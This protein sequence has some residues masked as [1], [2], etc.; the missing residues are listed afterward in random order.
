MEFNIN[1]PD[2]SIFYKPFSDGAWP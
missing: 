1:F 2:F